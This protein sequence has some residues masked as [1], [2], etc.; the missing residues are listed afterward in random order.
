MPFTF[1][2]EYFLSRCFWG[3][4][5]FLLND[6]CISRHCFHKLCCILTVKPPTETGPDNRNRNWRVL[7][8]TASQP[9]PETTGTDHNRNSPQPVHNR[10]RPQLQPAATGKPTTGPQPEPPEPEQPTTVPQPELVETVT[11]TTD[12]VDN[13]NRGF[14]ASSARSQLWA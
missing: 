8:T 9:Q 3:T 1:E 10:N 13:R 7:D 2:T 5:S 11:A 14:P 6:L 12:F 4:D